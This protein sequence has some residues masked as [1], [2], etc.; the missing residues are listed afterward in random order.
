MA[1]CVG[2]AALG[3]EPVVDEIF[4]D[5]H[6]G[7]CVDDGDVGARAAAAGSSGGLDVRRAHEVDATRVD[8]DQLGAV[9]QPAL[10]PRRE[11]RVG[12][13]GIGADQQDHVGLLDRLEVLRAGRRAE[14][15]A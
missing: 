4:G 1:K 5:D 6:V 2:L 11:H 3:D 8:D 15:A 7:Q 14:R 9:A 10:H 12:I 13:G